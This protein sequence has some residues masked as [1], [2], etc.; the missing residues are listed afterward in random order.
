MIKRELPTR[1]VEPL[2]EWFSRNRRD[3]PWRNRPRPYAVWV[4]EIMLQQTQVATVIPYFRRFVKQ[5][6]SVHRLAGAHLQE[7]LKAWEGLGYYTR[8]RNLHRA[9]REVVRRRDGRLPSTAAEWQTL[10]GVGAYTAAAIAS[11]CFNEAVPVLDGNVTR[12]FTRFLGIAR[13]STSPRVRRDILEFLGRHIPTTAPGD[14]NQAMMELGATVCR[15]RNPDCPACPLRR[16]C[17]ALK[18]GRTGSLPVRLRA[19]QTPTV[20]VAA[21]I[22]RKK[23]KILIARRRA[24][25]MLGG[26]WEFPGGKRH[27]GE[28]LEETVHRE[29]REEIGIAVRV[30]KEICVV[31][32]AYSHFKMRLHAFECVYRSGTASARASDE[33]R[34]VRAGDL[35][36]YPFP[37]ADRR[38][39]DLLLSEKPR[40]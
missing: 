15:P 2:L 6:P 35:R 10:P 36:A 21:A 34:W 18:T 13:V 4:S 5:F 38:I 30:G 39:L 31:K 17:V 11:I 8:A 7:V 27:R 16:G 22:V 23:G 37:V 3:M 33:V 14:F 40:S 28:S 19:K 24:D 29:I 25:Q 26:M 32:H 12:V 20:E 1:W 9:A